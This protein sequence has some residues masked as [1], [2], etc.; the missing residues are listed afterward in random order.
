M[1]F[2]YGVLFSGLVAQSHAD[3]TRNG[4]LFTQRR[5]CTDC[6]RKQCCGRWSIC[7]E[8]RC[9][10]WRSRG[11]SKRQKKPLILT[12]EQYYIVLELLPQPYRAMA[13]VSQCLGLRAVEVLA[14][15]WA[16]IDLERLV[17]RVSRAVVHGRI[18]T[19]KAEYS[20]DELPL[21]PDF[22]S[23]LLDW[24]AQAPRSELIFP[25]H[26]T[27][28]HFHASPV[29]QDYTRPAGCC[30][31][32]CPKCS[33]AVGAWCQDQT[34]KRVEVHQGKMGSGRSLLS[35]RMAYVPPH[36]SFV[37]GLDRSTAW[38]STET[39]AARSNLNHHERV[40]K[41]INGLE[42]RRQQQSGEI[43]VG[44]GLWPSGAAIRNACQ[45]KAPLILGFLG[46]AALVSGCGG[47]I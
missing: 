9:S 10:W 35:S 36:V 26:V 31:I 14:L 47:W 23:V 15:H 6:S 45:L 5:S 32:V 43:G 19:V 11:I 22:A 46:L 4:S 40:R 16:D 7:S 24:R 3:S 1:R 25:S 30:F 34:G 27:G 13:V 29:Q 21:D 18:K 2:S 37:A 44:Q 12:V 42:A 33:A 28:R 39:H 17:I 41:C 8:I 20:E 38:G